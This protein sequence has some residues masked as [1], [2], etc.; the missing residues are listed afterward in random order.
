MANVTME[1]VM[2]SISQLNTRMRRKIFQTPTSML[3]LNALKKIQ[4]ASAINYKA[5]SGY[6]LLLL[7]TACPTTSIPLL[8]A[9]MKIKRAT[10]IKYPAAVGSKS[11]Y[12]NK[13]HGKGEEVERTGP[14]V[15]LSAEYEYEEEELSNNDD[16]VSAGIGSNGPPRHVYLRASSNSG[17]ND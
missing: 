7:V 10:A 12:V 1:K 13:D 2:R 14:K 15:D 9:M 4:R 11:V 8:T 6:N 5:A 17:R 3:V 16:Y